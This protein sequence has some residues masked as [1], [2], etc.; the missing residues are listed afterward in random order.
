MK[1]L[2][3]AALVICLVFTAKVFAEE[4][5]A[6]INTVMAG[7]TTPSKVY[8]RDFKT[9]R[10]EMMGMVMI[11]N[12]ENF[13]QIVESTKKYVAMNIE[14][15]K[16]Q[17]PMADAEDFEDFI[18]KNNIKKAGTES[19][20]GYS[21]DIYEGNVTYDVNQPALGIKLWYSPELDYPVKTETQ[22][23][24]G[25]GTA[26]STLENIKTGKQP[27]NLF[28]LPAGYT[29]AQSMEEA[30]GLGGFMMPS[31]GEESN[32]MP[33]EEDMNQMMQMMQEVMGGQN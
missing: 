10:T 9:S 11:Q 32:E 3:F 23:P 33:S 29:Q 8:Y 2:L 1:K 28:E 18:Q 25:M 21:C 19:V 27:D 22:I 5:S 13:Y 15:L 30:M 26:V 31:G 24:G 14:E 7:M 4:F 6:D 17:N 16:Q 12:G 20:G